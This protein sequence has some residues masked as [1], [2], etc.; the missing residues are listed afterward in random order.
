MIRSVINY[1]SDKKEYYNLEKQVLQ[2]NIQLNILSKDCILYD[3]QIELGQKIMNTFND[4]RNLFTLLIL[5]PQYGKTGTAIATLL[6]YTKS[7]DILPNKNIKY[8]TGLSDLEWLNQNKTRFP[9]I[10]KDNIIHRNGLIKFVKELGELKNALI[11]IDE[12]HIATKKEQTIFNIFK[13]IGFFDTKYLYENDI[14]IVMTT[15][16]PNGCLIDLNEW[17]K[18]IPNSVSI[19]IEPL[20]DNYISPTKLLEEGNVFQYKNLNC[21]KKNIKNTF[22]SYDDFKQYLKDNFNTYLNTSSFNNIKELKTDIDNQKGKFYNIIRIPTGISGYFTEET[23]KLIFKGDNY[24]FIVYDGLS[25]ITDI[26]D[27]LINKPYKPTIIF[28]KE[29]LRCSKT[30]VKKHLGILYERK[31]DFVDDSIIIQ[32][33]LGR[34]CGYEYNKH[35]KIYTNINSITKYD[36]LLKN[37]FTNFHQINWYSDTTRN[38]KKPD[39]INDVNLYNKQSVLVKQPSIKQIYKVIV[40]KYQQEAIFYYKTNLENKLGKS[41]YQLKAKN[42]NGYFELQP[43]IF[44]NLKITSP[45][46]ICSVDIANKILN[47]KINKNYSVYIILP[48]YKDITDR[49]TLEWWL[50]YKDI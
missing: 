20:N 46:N 2:T 12:N 10:L 43:S 11:F 21:L 30:I 28:I 38:I 42:S 13:N 32:G 26:N 6:A 50:L 36:S 23:F 14:K 40:F 16:T 17:N 45:N 7:N 5:P 19:L 25:D 31:T 8:I 22:Q 18:L 37:K 4:R 48:V 3:T 1:S 33:V 27:I 44:K 34:C 29:L 49:S 24:N 15:A 9:N 39:T 35:I 41:S 47:K